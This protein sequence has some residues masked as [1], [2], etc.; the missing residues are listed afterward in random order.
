MTTPAFDSFITALQLRDQLA[1][2][3][4]SAREVTE[5]YLNSITAQNPTLNAFMHVD[6]DAAMAQAAQLDEQ[7]AA[8]G[9]T[10]PLHGLPTAF[11]D[12]V[13]IAGMPTTFG[14]KVFSE[15]PPAIQDDAVAGNLKTA[16]ASLVG[17][18]TIPEFALS[19][20]SE[21][22]ISAPAGNPI[23]PTRTPGGSSG[24]AAAAV[25]A[26]MLPLAPG[27][28]GGGSIRIP[29]AATGLVGFKPGRGTIPTDE[30]AG[31]VG[32]LAVTGPLARN[33]A[34]AALLMDALMDP[35][36][37]KGSYLAAAQ[38]GAQDISPARVGFTTAAPF[39]PDL[40]I[41]LSKHA[42]SAL[43]QATIA[44]AKAGHQVNELE[45]SYAPNYHEHFQVTWTSKMAEAA[46]PEGAIDRMGPLAKHFMEL[47]A[48]RTAEYTANAEKQLSN[49]ADH[50][51]KQ[52]FED[53]DIVITP[54]LAFTPPKLGAFTALE[55]QADYEY[56]CQ[57]TPYTS[58]INVMGLPAISV[59]IHTDDDGFSW[60]VQAIGRPGA[61]T[62]LF[63]L[64]AHLESLVS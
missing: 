3:T 48:A 27:T 32:N 4:L 15:F 17:K 16:G 55:P 13:N 38:R 2:G 41:T 46:L 20:Y 49:W 36:Q 56:Q 19:C 52:L 35:T 42:V 11:K 14:S 57:F 21:N 53:A 60:S 40:N 29:A 61:E 33:V 54:V 51:R 28:D 8:S 62:E 10:G 50:T 34:D 25:A 39:H 63:K 18:T 31:G 22:L 64:A 58:M 43:T 45:L 26:G 6:A 9:A 1:A 12:T 24:G 37:S 47:A 23:D 59:P 5:T 30:Q 7:F 44:L